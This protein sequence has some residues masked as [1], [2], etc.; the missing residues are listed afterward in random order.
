MANLM[1]AH[2][3]W[4]NRP[5]DEGYFGLDDLLS[6]LRVERDS[7]AAYSFVAKD[8][9]VEASEDES[10]NL[11]LNDRRVG[12]THWSFDQ[13]GAVL[14]S[15]TPCPTEYL[16]TLPAAL[17]AQNLNYGL[18]RR[19]NKSA[20]PAKVVSATD[21][22]GFGVTENVAVMN[23]TMQVM[24]RQTDDG[25][26][27]ARSIHGSTF[28]A[29][30]VCD[31][32]ERVAEFAANA[33]WRTCPARPRDSRDVTRVA[34]AD[35]VIPGLDGYA[36][37]VREGDTIANRSVFHSD[38]NTFI[39]LCNPT[40][41]IDGGHAFMRAAILDLNDCGN[42][43]NTL[44]T[45][46]VDSICGNLI[47]WNVR[48]LQI[49]RGVHKRK[50]IDAW[51]AR[52]FDQLDAYAS[53]DVFEEKRIQAARQHVLAKDKESTIDLLYSKLRPMMT[54]SLAT[55]AW[56]I[57]SQEEDKSLAAPNTAWGVVYGLTVASQRPNTEGR[58]YSD[59][60]LSTDQ[61]GGKILDWVPAE[62]ESVSANVLATIDVEMTP[63]PAPTGAKR[64]RKSSS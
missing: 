6:T 32:V 58:Y 45:C 43:A 13:L 2:N 23:E 49:V 52:A 24:L 60:R 30:W 35:D 33:G 53:M 25:D 42:G 12:F 3:Q 41:I 27:L 59:H 21:K 1:V 18:V 56:E 37:A 31:I 39:T 9:R 17:A 62:A 54:K 10:L 22:F 19:F 44:Y 15:E 4:S 50:A 48:N 26:L 51:D 14:R 16:R 11:V 28:G 36:L 20:L 38:R 40:R 46:L 47:L 7:S 55:Q 34:T 61:I 8:V 29:R 64:G 63:V 57:A 5:T